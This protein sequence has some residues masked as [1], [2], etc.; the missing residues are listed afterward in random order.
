VLSRQPWIAPATKPAAVEKAATMIA[1]RPKL[2]PGLEQGM[3][4]VTNKNYAVCNPRKPYRTGVIVGGSN[5]A[6]GPCVIHLDGDKLPR[7]MT[8]NLFDVV[9]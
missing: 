9:K 7:A 1:P 2:P 4:I 3:K 8:L 5:S 6:L